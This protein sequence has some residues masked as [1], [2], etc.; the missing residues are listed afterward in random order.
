MSLERRPAARLAAF[1]A[2]G[3]CLGA[4]EAAGRA[5]PAPPALQGVDVQER[6]GERVPGA[7]ELRDE[8]GRA[9]PLSSFL[10]GGGP[11]LLTLGYYRCPML[12]DVVFTG[13]AGGLAGLEWT[14]GEQFRVL[15]VSIDPR[16]GP[17]E[18][19]RKRAEVLAQYGREI[20]PEGWQFVTAREEEVHA[21]ADAVGFRYRYVAESE[22]YAH[23]AVV[24]A[25]TA[26]GRVAR[27]LYGVRWSPDTLRLA[28]VEAGEGRI[29]TSLDRFIL[30]CFHYDAAESRYV[31]AAWRIMRLGALATMLV[32]GLTLTVFWRRELR[33]GRRGGG[34]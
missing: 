32:L 20:P 1:A 24:V 14:P 13:L 25:L 11:V 27:Y 23:P 9:R 4:G 33:R 18:A 16:E 17:I 7:I 30:Y 15:S 5:E 8:T 12:C 31:P 22:Q 26:D 21:L 2:L 6:L 29:G 3:L 19:R 34:A 10:G 28:L